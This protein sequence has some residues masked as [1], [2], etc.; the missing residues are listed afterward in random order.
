MFH[1]AEPF[2]RPK[3][4]AI[5]GASETGGGG[6]AKAIY[7]NLEYGGFPAKTY[8]INPRREELWGHKVYPNFSSIPERIDLALTIVPAPFVPEVL[9]EGVDAGL[10]AALIYAARF[11]EGND[12]EGRKRADAIKSI[13]DESGLVVCG[14]NCMGALSLHNRQLFYPATRVRSIGAGDVGVVFQSGGTFMFWL[15]R[16]FIRGLDF[17]FA[18]SSG[19]ELNLD[20]ADYIN[21]LV[22]DPETKMIACMVEGIRRPEPF[23]E[24]IRRA[25]EAEK[26]VLMVKVGR[27]VAGIEAAQS[28]TGALASD[29]SV[30]TAVC[31]RYGVT[32][33]YSLDE[34]IEAALVL[35]Q[36]RWPSGPNIAMAG[37]SG[38]GKG[39]FLDYADD[40]GAVMATLSEETVAAC[41]TEIDEGL[42]GQNPIDCGAGIAFRPQAFSWLCQ[43]VV[44]DAGVDIMAI[45][46]QLPTLDD[47]PADPSVFSDV[48]DLTDKP[49]IAFTRVS[50]NVSDAGRHF[51][52]RS[53]VPFIQG[54]DSTVKAL[55]HLVNYGAARRRGIP[56]LPEVS[57]C[58]QDFSEGGLASKLKSHGLIPPKSIL[59]S[60]IDGAV[61]ASREIGFPVAVKIVSPQASHKTEVGGVAIN[62]VDAMETEKVAKDMIARLYRHDP[63]AV[64]EGFLVQEMVE[65]LE[66][67]LGAREDVQFGPF[68]V[69]GIGG[70]AVEAMQDISLRMLPVNRKTAQEMLEELRGKSLFGEFRGRPERDIEAL[71]DAMC[72]LSDLF[73]AHRNHLADLEI[74]PLMLGEKGQGARAVDVRLVT[75]KD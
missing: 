72:G 19:N 24:A 65:G 41:E 33:C 27:S 5:V 2:F 3:T 23:K 31:Q 57:G 66:I 61:R 8:L 15:E 16:A 45:Q 62:V 18:V 54:L 52:E 42:S 17:S 28:H 20:L 59:A 49:T 25:F 32:R 13:C 26:P 48:F 30:L 73:C 51:Q 75:R 46:G 4:V 67:I 55:Q 47:D 10:K 63:S 6:W 22:E 39:L 21:F 36:R 74:N 11:G 70:V 64:F 50:Q 43:Q 58:S 37:Y 1:S 29:D 34:M 71:I 44:V 12:P 69:V 14:P 9:Q 60:D 68:M 38:G 56:A 35:R 53:K 40:Q 7:Q